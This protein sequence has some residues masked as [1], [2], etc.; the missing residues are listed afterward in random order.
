MKKTLWGTMSLVML[1]GAGCA[2]GTAKQ[3]GGRSQETS[4]AAAKPIKIAYNVWV[5]SAGVYVADAKKYFA[6]QGLQ[7]ELA[8]FASPTDAAQAVLTHQADAAITTLDTVVMMKD[9]ED[10]SNPLQAVHTIDISNGADG[11]VAGS[12]MKS[13][14]DLKGKKVAVTVGAVNQFLLNHALQQAG[15]KES[16][17]TAVNM[18]PDTAGSTFLAGNVDAAVTWE[19]FLSEAKAKGGNLIYSTKD[20][21]NL[22]VD[23]LAVSKEYASKHPEDLKKM[24]QAIDMGL[25][26]FQKN[27]K[28]G[29]EI[30]AKVMG[31]KPE[32]VKGLTDG[33]Q[34]FTQKDAKI[35]FT[36]DLSKTQDT[37]KQLSDFYLGQK[38][39]KKAVDPKSVLNPVL[40]Q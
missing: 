13:V 24:V 33:I 1:L 37:V 7:V 40:Y 18:N 31:T 36:S 21:P 9:N 20:A 28:E 11:I 4:A 19:P 23:V 30:V 5:G 22:I 39:I 2:S 26:Y 35:M 8:Q 27:E 15:L 14:A 32:E 12:G 10:A 16:D 34:L 29:S 3:T 6:D 25:D 38:L 17:V